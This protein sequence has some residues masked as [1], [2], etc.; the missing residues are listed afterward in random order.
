MSEAHVPLLAEAPANHQLCP[1]LMHKTASHALHL[2]EHQMPLLYQYMSS[3]PKVYCFLFH[4]KKMSNSLSVPVKRKDFF[5][6][7]F[8]KIFHDSSHNAP[9][10]FGR[11]DTASLK[12]CSGENHR[13]FVK[14]VWLS[15]GALRGPWYCWGK[16]VVMSG[17]CLQAGDRTV[18]KDLAM[19][20][21]PLS[22]GQ[23]HS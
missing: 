15:R 18:T 13:N 23:K 9:P 21:K 7:S 22:S 5:T 2:T 3:S 16:V 1:R 17:Q 20:G 8:H 12:K 4:S 14:C 11:Y 10:S 6:A 19:T